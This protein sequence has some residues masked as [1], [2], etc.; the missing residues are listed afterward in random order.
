MWQLQNSYDLQTDAA[1]DVPGSVS[2]SVGV[3]EH[4][5]TRAYNGGLR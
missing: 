4:E 3:R 1:L 2:F 5:R